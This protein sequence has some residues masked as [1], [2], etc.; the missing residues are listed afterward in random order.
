[1]ECDENKQHYLV[2]SFCEKFDL[3][4]CDLLLS[5]VRDQHSF[6]CTEV[7]PSNLSP[8]TT[9]NLIDEIDVMKLLLLENRYDDTYQI[10]FKLLNTQRHSNDSRL[11]IDLCILQSYRRDYESAYKYCSSASSLDPDSSTAL[12]LLGVVTMYLEGRK[13][14]AV[15]TL[16]K[17][18]QLQQQS[19][20]KS[21]SQS[22]LFTQSKETTELNLLRV[23]NTEGYYKECV[24]ISQVILDIPSL[25]QGGA[26]I[27]IFATV[28]WSSHSE[29]GLHNLEMILI[30]GGALKLE[31]G[32]T[33]LGEVRRVQETCKHVLVNAMLGIMEY[34]SKM[35]GD[36]GSDL[37]SNIYAELLNIIS[38]PEALEISDLPRKQ[39][40]HE[41][42]EHQKGIALITQYFI[43]RNNSVLKRD[44]D[45]VLRQNLANP[46]IS[47]IYVL[48]EELIDFSG[49]ID[50]TN[51]IKQTVIGERLTF[52][53]AFTFANEHLMGRLVA[54]VNADI[55]FDE[56]LSQFGDLVT[57]D[58]HGDV[59]ALSRWSV[60]SNGNRNLLL[61]TDAQDAWI[62]QPNIKSTVIDEGNFYL[63][64]VKCD[65]RIAEILEQSGHHVYNPTF[66]I[67]AIEVHNSQRNP[68]GFYLDQGLQESKASPNGPI[69]DVLIS[70]RYIF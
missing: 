70:D 38:T 68:Q 24:G 30:E 27:I 60:D 10:A 32:R 47:D 33:F 31:K 49:F 48:T 63:G 1:M 52:S 4:S 50:K 11:L 6:Q 51:K 66:A 39:R 54:L 13:V 53:A 29:K 44:I 25:D 5:N 41:S 69:R 17:S 14:E 43:P 56:S 65:N 2:K 62:F 58:L 18:W 8:P 3:H 12:H 16:I 36:K 45:L 21:S 42:L 22:Y 55:Y 46:Y 26:Y 35:F 37:I 7:S 61:R 19:I 57:L 34:L 59:L 23:L 9:T 67:H 40:Q 64:V 15:N 20:Y 28:D